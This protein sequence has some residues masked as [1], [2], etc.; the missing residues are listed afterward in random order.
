MLFM[1]MTDGVLPPSRLTE[2]VLYHIYTIC[3]IYRCLHVSIIHIY[4]DMLYIHT[5]ICTYA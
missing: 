5:D 3:I 4:I 2:P 1:Y